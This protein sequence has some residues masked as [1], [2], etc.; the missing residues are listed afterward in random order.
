ME[1]A[2]IGQSTNEE[3]VVEH[4]I[5]L[6]VAIPKQLHSILEEMAVVEGIS[7]E[8]FIVEAAMQ[9]LENVDDY[10]VAL[11]YQSNPNRGKDV[12]EAKTFF[13]SLGYDYV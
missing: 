8:S 9:R 6:K 3:V 5:Q 13:E 2:S 7:I 1:Q 4:T 12:Q 11:E 10:Q